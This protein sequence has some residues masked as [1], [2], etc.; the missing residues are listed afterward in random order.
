MHRTLTPQ[1]FEIFGFPAPMLHDIRR[2]GWVQPTPVQS[3]AIPPALEGRDVIASAQTG[4]G[5]TGAFALPIIRKLSGGRGLRALV[6]APT[7]ELALQ[8]QDTFEELGRESRVVS[9]VAYGGVGLEPQ[10]EALRRNPDVLVATPGRLL[11]LLHRRATKLAALKV[12]VLDEA[13]RMLDMGFMPQIRRILAACPRER[14]TMLFSATIPPGIERLIYDQLREPVHVTIGLRTAPAERAIQRVIVCEPYAKEQ[15]LMGL[16][17][18]EDGTMLVF[19]RTRIRAERL[20][21][22]LRTAGY[23]AARLHSSRTQTQRESALE[24]FRNGRYRILVATDI[25]ARGIDVANIAH[26]V[27]YDIPQC[28]DDYV[29]RVGRT[30]RLEASGKATTLVAPLELH[31][32]KLIER[33]IG[34]PI[35][36]LQ[37]DGTP[38]EE[39]EPPPPPPFGRRPKPVSQ[40]DLMRRF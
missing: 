26:V 32:L 33:A 11:D 34:R 22:A 19:T 2:A 14:Q 9:T 25:A 40:R 3:Q 6:L 10:I 36:K 4:T 20:G 18:D 21:R 12:L 1:A 39:P 13:D 29:H 27:N 7:R 30:A 24:G 23:H 35:P 37:A 8:T 5:K 16:L 31:D 38:I 15:V 17:A 28:A